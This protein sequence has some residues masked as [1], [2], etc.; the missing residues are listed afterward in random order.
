MPEETEKLVTKKISFEEAWQMVETGEIT[1]SISI[2][3]FQKLKILL[4]E[5][6]LSL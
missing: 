1:D 5:K 6:K 3:A 2:I 4:A